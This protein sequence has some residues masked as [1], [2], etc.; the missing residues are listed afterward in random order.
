MRDN[1]VETA[2]GLGLGLRDAAG[3]AKQA[4]TVWALANRNDLVPPQLSCGFEDV[5]YTRLRRSVS[6]M[7]GHWTSSRIA[8]A[9]F[10]TEQ[11]WRLLRDEAPG[12]VLL[13]E[14]RAGQHNLLTKAASCEGLEP[15]GPVGYAYTTAVAGTLALQRCNVG[16]GAD[17]FVSTSA[18]CEGQTPEGLLGFVLGP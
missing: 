1:P 3:N 6:P 7:R 4:W 12:T 9:G 2:A 8:P 17:H 11:S 10:T 13:Y 14:C 5:P 18:T 16:G 15:L